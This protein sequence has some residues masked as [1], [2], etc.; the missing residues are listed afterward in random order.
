MDSAIEPAAGIKPG[1]IGFLRS[2]QTHEVASCSLSPRT[3]F[4]PSPLTRLTRPVPT[5]STSPRAHPPT[6]IATASVML[7][8]QGCVAILLLGAT[9]L[10]TIVA[11]KA[12]AGGLA[13]SAAKARNW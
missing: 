10:A 3:C 7:T 13:A 12:V 8:R 9:V 1:C 4:G 6:G 2:W 11:P 5:R